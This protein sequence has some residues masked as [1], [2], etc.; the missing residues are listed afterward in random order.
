MASS[1]LC[2]SILQHTCDLTPDEK[3]VE[4]HLHSVQS[5][6]SMNQISVVSLTHSVTLKHRKGTHIVALHQPHIPHLK[7]TRPSLNGSTEELLKILLEICSEP[8][9]SCIERMK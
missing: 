2:S 7:D 9:L 1:I 6:E 5:K 8:T 3:A 4:S